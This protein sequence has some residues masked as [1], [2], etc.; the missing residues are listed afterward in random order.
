MFNKPIE[1][2]TLNVRKI[3]CSYEV[4]HV[5]LPIYSKINSMIEGRK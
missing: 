4:N 5:D 2:G 3:G 1:C